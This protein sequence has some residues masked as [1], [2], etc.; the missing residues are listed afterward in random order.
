MIVFEDGKVISEYHMYY[1]SCV[2]D[3]YNGLSYKI[4]Q[5]SEE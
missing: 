3:D 4:P 5:E 1:V 2:N